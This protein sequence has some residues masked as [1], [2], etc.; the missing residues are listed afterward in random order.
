MT[1]TANSTEPNE[2]SNPSRRWQTAGYYTAFIILGLTSASFGP[3][4]TYLAD[5]TQTQLSQ[6]SAL[7]AFRSL[8]YLLGSLRGG[9]LYDH[10]P[11]HPVLTGVLLALAACMAMVPAVP[12]LIPLIGILFVIG[13]CEGTMDVGG[14]TLIIWAHGPKVGPFMNGL[15]F[16][17]GI[18]AF[19]APIFIAQAVLLTGRYDAAYWLIAL[20]ILPLAFFMSR[21]PSPIN[22]TARGSAAEKPF[23]RRL[24]V[25]LVLFFFLYVGAEVSFGGWVFTYATRLNLGDATI[26]ALITSAFWGALT[27]GRLLAIPVSTRLDPKTILWVDLIGCGL[28]MFLIVLFP[29]VAA[30]LWIGT[31]LL[32]LSMASIF[33]TALTLAEKRL[34]ISGK[35]TSWF[36]IGASL[37]G[38]V[39][40]WVIGQVFDPLGPT[41]AMALIFGDV[42]LAILLYFFIK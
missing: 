22:H 28:S 2:I 25:L 36:F 42:L 18:G 39:L 40:P 33:P 19:L 32:G 4:L 13:L 14:N 16:F 31:L 30:V 6:I 35:I 10:R 37:G 38:M 11:G 5:Q 9:W 27:V 41:A 3:A 7:F 17:F 24:V 20:L 23:N 29:T 12:L 21:V 15:H 8:G 1:I 34:H 26:A